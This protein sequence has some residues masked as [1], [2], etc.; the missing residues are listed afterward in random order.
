MQKQ[1]CELGNDIS[2]TIT[3]LHRKE[4][5]PHVPPYSIPETLS[6]AGQTMESCGQ[7]D[8]TLYGPQQAH[9]HGSFGQ[10]TSRQ[11]KTRHAES[12]CTVHRKN[13]RHNIF[14]AVLSQSMVYG[15]PTTL[16]LA[17][18]VLCHS[19]TVLATIAP[20]S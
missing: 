6:D 20:S 8:Y 12:K 5:G 11:G 1:K 10:G 14:F 13:P 3:I 7:K 15:Y 19:D 16:T 2:A 4:E 9:D 18:H 17:T